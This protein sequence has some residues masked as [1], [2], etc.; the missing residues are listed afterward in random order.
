[1]QGHT[2]THTST[3]FS[4]YL[5]NRVSSRTKCTFLAL[6]FSIFCFALLLLFLF[7]FYY[8]F[9]D[10]NSAVVL[11]VGYVSEACVIFMH[12]LSSLRLSNN[13]QY[14]AIPKILCHF[15][16]LWATAPSV[17]VISATCHLLRQKNNYRCNVVRSAKGEKK[18]PA[19]KIDPSVFIPGFSQLT[20]LLLWLSFYDEPS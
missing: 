16:F 9:W 3:N 5:L 7:P 12:F 6:F 20:K 18:R 11:L 15:R 14:L 19:I 2:H 8:Y 4:I 17:C 10:A 13:S 1:M